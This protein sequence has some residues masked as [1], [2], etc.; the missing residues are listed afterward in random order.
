MNTQ[1]ARQYEVSRKFMKNAIKDLIPDLE[2]IFAELRVNPVWIGGIAIGM[3]S[4]PV[5]TFD[6]DILISQEDFLTLKRYR[7]DYGI[8]YVGHN[9]FKYRGERLDCIVEGENIEGYLAP[10]PDIIRES[11]YMPRVEGIFYLK[12][13][14]NRNKD[15]WHLSILS[16]K[17]ELDELK[18][19]EIIDYYGYLEVWNN[20][21]SYKRMIEL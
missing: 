1:F 7:E 15:K 5:S 9:T 20:Y 16:E 13:M 11:G 3:M 12:L 21:L 6:L 8:I 17:Q 14:A 10:S 2:D 19:K 18:L 4:E